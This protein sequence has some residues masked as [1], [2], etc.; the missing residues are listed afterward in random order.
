MTEKQGSWQN[1][2]GKSHKSTEKSATNNKDINI[3]AKNDQ[4]NGSIDKEN[5]NKVEG[6][7]NL[8][9]KL[10]ESEAKAADL[11]NKL[12]RAL[13]EIENLRRRHK[14]D[15][16]KASN[17]AISS[18]V[19][20]LVVVVENFFLACDNLP[21]VEE[22][23]SPGVKSL[24]AAVEMTKKELMKVLQ[25]NNVERVASLGEKFDHHIHEAVSHIE[26]DN[27]EGEIIKVIQAGYRMGQRIIKPS[28]VVVSKGPAS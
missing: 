26:S 1:K 19:T 24:V 11:N 13:A 17:F 21:N 12:L 6:G 25:K 22:G 9:Q 18:F 5:V 4:E 14:D 3:N 23:G 15:L 10:Q 7:N 27:E 2:M 28:L 20:D 16:E 8:M